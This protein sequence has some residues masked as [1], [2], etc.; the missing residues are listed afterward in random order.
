MTRFA[1]F[2]STYKHNT[3]TASKITRNLGYAGIAF[4]WGLRSTDD[5]LPIWLLVVCG[6]LALGLMAD[7]L[8]Y[9]ITSCMYWLHYRKLQEAG[10]KD[11]DSI[12]V[13]GR[14]HEPARVCYF[15]KVFLILAAYVVL[16]IYLL[17]RMHILG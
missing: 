3:E 7:V 2:R 9:F 15:S 10:L 6:L 12:A 8:Q 13:P 14:L 17:E 5:S 4:V 1:D 16:L 11:S